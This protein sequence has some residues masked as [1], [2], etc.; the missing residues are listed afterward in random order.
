MKE[1]DRYTP[2]LTVNIWTEENGIIFA[3]IEAYLRSQ[4]LKNALNQIDFP[5]TETQITR[6]L[7]EWQKILE[8]WQAGQTTLDEEFNSNQIEMIELGKITAIPSSANTPRQ[9]L[10]LKVDEMVM[11]SVIAA[12]ML[13]V[14][15]ADDLFPAI[16]GGVVKAGRLYT[17]SL[18]ALRLLDGSVNGCMAVVPAFVIKDNKVVPQKVERAIEDFYRKYDLK[19][20][21]GTPCD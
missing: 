16:S 6:T 9:L 19:Y 11:G 20:H 18:L 10:T 8:I 17:S 21:F 1:G 14:I 3:K 4:Y 7:T 15:P 5:L 13:D 2:E 12:I